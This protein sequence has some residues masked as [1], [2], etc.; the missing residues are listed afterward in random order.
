MRDEGKPLNSRR[1]VSASSFIPHPSSL[2]FGR[3]L[4]PALRADDA[5]L[6][7]EDA[8][9]PLRVLDPERAREA[10]VLDDLHGVEDGD[11]GEVARERDLPAGG[12]RGGR[13]R[14]GRVME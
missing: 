13:G 1:A 10:R 6:V 8:A 7:E 9:A 5:P 4:G 14:R 11:G 3:L 2:L 12:F